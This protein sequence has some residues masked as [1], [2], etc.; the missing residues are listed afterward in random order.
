MSDKLILKSNPLVKS[1]GQSL[2]VK[3]SLTDLVRARK[4][5]NIMLLLDCSGSMGARMQ[6]GKTRMQGLREAVRDIQAEKEM[7]MAQFGYGFEP[8]LITS[9]PDASGGT[10]LHLGIDFCRN[11]KSGRVIV[12]S[13]GYPDNPNFAL[14]AAQRFGGRIDVVFIG[15][16]GEAGEAFL[17]RLAESTG[18]ESFTG[19]LKDPK[20]LAG[21]VIAL[22][23]D[24]SDA[25]DED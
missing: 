3:G 2:R 24:G 23:T 21:Q 10:P 12:I 4:E 6:N 9:I 16:P 11:Q 15:E 20:Q 1:L 19:D 8:S 14:E 22:L 13:D 7:P 5:S 25:D 17:K 18:G